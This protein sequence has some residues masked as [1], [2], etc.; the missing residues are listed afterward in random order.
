MDAVEA[1]ALR[2]N[3]RY[4]SKKWKAILLLNRHHT[5]Q[6]ISPLY[7]SANFCMVTS[8]HDGM[9]LVAKEFVASRDR[10]DGVL[11]LSRFTGAS[12]E[13]QSA[14]II[15][16]YDIEEAADAIKDALEMTPEEQNQRM[17]HMRMVIVKH[18]IFSWAASILRTMASIN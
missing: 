12:Q 2:I 10:N 1:E 16:P 6:E 15:N 17:K 9:N 11:I 14:I 3:Q 18:N 5:H 7:S 4:K 8:L 13:L